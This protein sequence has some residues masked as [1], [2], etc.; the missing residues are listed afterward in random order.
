MLKSAAAE[1]GVSARLVAVAA[2]TPNPRNARTHPPEQVAQI[3]ASIREFG[4]T[5]PILADMDDDGLIVAGH[6]R[7]LA[8]L[9][10]IAADEPIKLPNGRLLPKGTVPVIDCAGWTEKQ[11]RA[12][13]LADNQLALTSGWDDELLKL[14][15]S[16]LSDE[17]FDLALTGFDVKSIEKM[18][19]APD[20]EQA[21][22]PRPKLA[23]RFGIAPFS[24]LNAREGWWQERKRLWLS[25]G[26]QS[27]VGRGEN[28]LRFSD[29]INEPDPA[30][31]KAKN[32]KRKAATFGQDLMRGEH[33]VGQTQDLRGGLTHRTTTDPYRKETASLKGGLTHGITAHAYDGQQGGTASTSGTSIFDPVLCEL[34]YRW[35][36]PPGGVILDPFAGGSVRGIVASILG[37][38]Y[39]GGELRPEQVEANRAQAAAICKDHAPI[40]NVGDSRRIGEHCAGTEADF[41]FSCPPYCDLEVYSDDPADLSTLAYA[42]FREAYFEIIAATCAMLKPDRFAAF[43]VGEVRDKKGN[44][45]GFVPDTI[46]G[47]RRAGLEFYNEAILVTAA[48]SLPIRA[49]KQFEATRKLG[50]THQQ[51]LVFLKGD[52]KRAV[53]A[54]GDVE[55]GDIELGDKGD[56]AAEQ[57]GEKL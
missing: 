29:T 41:V 49:G 56:A 14:E 17:G 46:E 26:I 27:E 43:V 36:C 7:R 42:E 22:D 32:G 18:L 39:V 19:A 9:D 21:E 35:F 52:A 54:I 30:K 50:K 16:F 13:T 28:L 45:Y 55:F 34:A 57:W 37:R 4:F 5:Q 40:W 25:L 2:L 48:G 23:E 47:F 3:V 31:R 1:A 24:V 33:V 11:R 53:E 6:G 10:L 12:Y 8:V 38:E 15:I 51:V 20:E 44:Y